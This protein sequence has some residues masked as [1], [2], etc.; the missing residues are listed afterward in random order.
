M[1][2]LSCVYIVAFYPTCPTSAVVVIAL[3]GGKEWYLVPSDKTTK[4]GTVPTL[5]PDRVVLLVIAGTS[6][7]VRSM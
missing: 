2:V 5:R 1:Q 7:S 6:L 3:S 4:F